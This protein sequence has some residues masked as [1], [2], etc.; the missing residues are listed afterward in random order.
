MVGVFKQALGVASAQK[1][2]KQKNVLARMFPGTRFGPLL[3]SQ[4][5]QHYV[6]HNL[7]E[8]LLMFPLPTSKSN[9]YDSCV[10]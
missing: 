1:A 3:G 6:Q 5:S 2:V 8:D 4:V 10:A 9:L 7:D